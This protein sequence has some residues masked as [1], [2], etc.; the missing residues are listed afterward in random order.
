MKERILKLKNMYEEGINPASFSKLILH[1]TDGPVDHV[2]GDDA[3]HRRLHAG[4]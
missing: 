1:S 2:R 4:E 3:D